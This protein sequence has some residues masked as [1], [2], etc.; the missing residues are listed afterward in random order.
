MQPPLLINFLKAES[1]ADRLLSSPWKGE[2]F[3]SLLLLLGKISFQ[4]GASVQ[5]NSLNQARHLNWAG[6]P[7][8]LLFLTGGFLISLERMKAKL[9]KICH[10]GEAVWGSHGPLVDCYGKVTCWQKNSS[11]EANAESASHSS[12]SVKVASGPLSLTVV[13]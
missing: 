13:S 7:D 6:P 5:F 10:L 8:N 9:K 2:G 11:L 3:S 1:H 4:E 12:L